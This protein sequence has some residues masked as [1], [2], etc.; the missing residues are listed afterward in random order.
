[1]VTAIAT[2]GRLR[3]DVER[4]TRACW[5]AAH[6][7][8][9]LLVGGYFASG[10][11]AV[12]LLRDA[13]R[14]HVHILG[15]KPGTNVFRPRTSEHPEDEGFEGM[16]ILRTEGRIYFANAQQLGE[17]IWTLIHEHHPKVLI[18]E[19][20]AVPDME[21]TA[22][23]QLTDAEEKLRESGVTLWLV[24]LNPAVLDVIAKSPLGP[25]FGRDRM[26][27]NLEQAVDRWLRQHATA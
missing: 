18:L 3:V 9:S 22:L 23:R 10:D 7:V 11:P 2:A 6:G 12:A 5:C 19:L 21:Y 16:L 27:F 20:S 1:M 15:R 8:T 26:F 17:R 25:R 24:A 14:P 13:N 4:A